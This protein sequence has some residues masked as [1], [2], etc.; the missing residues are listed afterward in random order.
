MSVATEEQILI[1]NHILASLSAEEYERLLP[2]LEQVELRL[3]EILSRPD[4]PIEYAYF[5]QSGTISVI[6]LMEDGSQVEIGIVGNEGMFGLPIV[7]GT[8]SAPLQAIV[9]IAGQALRIKASVLREKAANGGQL[10]QLLLC[11]TQAFFIQT[12]I[13]AACNRVHHL[14]GRLARW[15]LMCQDRA[16]TDELQLTHEFIAT[17]LGV[18]RAGVSVAANKLQAA[19]LISYR[20]GDIH[21]LDREGLE[22]YSCECYGVV[23]RE[24]ARLLA[25]C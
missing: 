11:Y 8:T 12:A 15:L 4:E 3:G 1:L 5:P 6:V 10:H 25:A 24:L 20:R 22:A 2:H 13:T 19:G 17:M 7:L 9:Q 18:R 16:Q 21:I 14:D 23:R